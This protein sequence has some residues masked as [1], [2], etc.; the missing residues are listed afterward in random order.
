MSQDYAKANSKPLMITIAGSD[1]SAGAGIQADLKAGLMLGAYP[2]TVLSCATAQVPGNVAG[3]A[4][5]PAS[6]VAQ[7]LE[8]CLRHYPV[9]AIKT[10][11]LYSSEIIE[12]LA[13][14]LEE[15]AQGIPLV[16]DPVMIATSSQSLM[17]DGALSHYRS[18]LFPM[19][20]LITP[21]KD[22]LCALTRRF[23]IDS[24]EGMLEAAREL[25]LDLGCAVLA[26]GGHLEGN[27]C[28][29]S[30][31]LANGEN[32]SWQHARVEGVSTH[33]TGCT[34]SAAVTALLAQGCDLWQ[35][36]EGG[37]NYVKQAISSSYL[38]THH[39]A[40]EALASPFPVADSLDN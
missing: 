23:D 16:I 35:A 8:L 26:K 25:A 22:E 2:L 32:R 33:G 40:M 19:A 7:Q 20:S 13:D 36:V 31:V 11:M 14:V 18:R 38:W 30:L 24:A 17:Q 37:L 9:G 1:S 10:G 27:S 29:D 5:L 21:N 34:L 3:I 6:F 28:V 39:C 4:P 15:H 12:A